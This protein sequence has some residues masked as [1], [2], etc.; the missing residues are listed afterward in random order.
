VSDK[1]DQKLFCGIFEKLRRVVGGNK[2]EFNHF[3]INKKS[4]IA[5]YL[6]W[7]DLKTIFLKIIHL[8]MSIFD[9]PGFFHSRFFTLSKKL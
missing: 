4:R 3:W 7:N 5:G 9:F 8:K 6:N 2:R 1:K